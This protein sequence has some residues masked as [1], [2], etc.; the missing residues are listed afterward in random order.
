MKR[1]LAA[2]IILAVVASAITSAGLLLADGPTDLERG[3][4]DKALKPSEVT[5]LPDGEL[6]TALTLPYDF[7][8]FR[9]T[10]PSSAYQYC[11]DESGRKRTDQLTKTYA[12]DGSTGAQGA[13]VSQAA[14]GPEGR[15]EAV[16]KLD[17]LES[18]DLFALPGFVPKGWDLAYAETFEVGFADGSHEDGGFHAS[19]D[20]PGHFYIDVRRFAIP[21]GC[22]FE[23]QDIGRV[24][25]S[26]HAI[27]LTSLQGQP[28]VIQ[29][30]APG[31]RIQATLQIMFIQGN[32]VTIVESVAMDLDELT[33]VAESLA[34]GGS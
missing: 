32:I 21:A 28:A 6:A 33:K 24:P 14:D 9:I 22:H 12:R 11:V 5:K 15:M 17:D 18:H 1:S 34:E 25:D 19:Y 10:D 7:G 13:S 26:Q 31:E 16:T 29:H 3:F 2:G 4:A 8:R 30:Q 20:Q 27:T 23:V